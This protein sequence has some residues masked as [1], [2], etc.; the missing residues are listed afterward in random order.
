MSEINSA[1]INQE[2]YSFDFKNS[3]EFLKKETARVIRA[4]KSLGLEGLTGGLEAIIINTQDYQHKPAVKELLATTGC[5]HDKSYSDADYITSILKLKNSADILIRERINPENPFQ[6]FN[7]NPKSEHLPDTRLETFIFNS[8][9]IARYYQIQKRKGIKFL[10]PDILEYD[11]YYFIQSEPS[12]YTGISIGIIQ[13]K[14]NIGEYP[15]KNDLVLSWDFKKPARQYL[16]NISY[17]DH[18]ATRVRAQDRDPAIIEFMELTNYN[19]DFAIYVKNLNSITN[20]A[21]LSSKDFAMVF[22]SGIAPFKNPE[23]SG[24]TEKFIFNYGT[25]THHMAFITQNIEDT[26]QELKNDGVKYLV[27][28]IGSPEDGLK[29]TF[30]VAS[31]NT[32]LVNEYIHRYGDFTGFFTRQNVTILT[33]ATNKQ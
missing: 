23:E 12:D 3:D 27:E 14:K 31:P 17:L 10:T 8:P 16:H 15:G 21:R 32:L 22:T 13:W 4:R 5:Y 9:D 19:F 29:Q 26:Y 18:T 11:N 33:D 2:G 28:L 6:K 1:V 7:L 25:R 20:V 24:P 30:T